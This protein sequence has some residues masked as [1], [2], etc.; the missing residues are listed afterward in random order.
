METDFLDTLCRIC[1][2]PLTDVAC[3][4][5]F[6]SEN[7]EFQIRGCLPILVYQGDGLPQSICENCVK[8][9]KA[10]THFRKTSLKNDK[11]LK[12]LKHKIGP[13]SG[14]TQDAHTIYLGLVENRAITEN[15]PAEVDDFEE[16]S[17]DE[18]KNFQLDEDT[19]N[20]S[21]LT[22][23]T[24][25]AD[26]VNAVAI[27]RKELE[28]TNRI[29]CDICGKSYQIKKKLENHVLTHMI[30]KIFRCEKCR[31]CFATKACLKT[32]EKR[33]DESWRHVCNEC[34]KGFVDKTSFN[35]H[36]RSKHTKLKPFK[37][38]KCSKSFFKNQDLK[39]HVRRN[40]SA[41]PENFAKVCPVCNKT[42]RDSE[43]L[44]LHAK[45]HISLEQRRKYKCN[46]CPSSFACS[47]ALKKHKLVH[48]GEMPF[49]CT[50]CGHKTRTKKGMDVHLIIHS[51]VKNFM[52]EVCGKSFAFENTLKFHARTHTGE[53]PFLCNLCG[54][55]YAQ[56]SSYKKHVKSCGKKKKDQ[57]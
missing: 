13:D 18:S 43:A 21:V 44:R 34:H 57:P 12:E 17:C 54:K 33:H 45:T 48:T 40:H 53:K 50:I 35:Y 26:R 46:T 36:V 16:A 37:C 38:D 5:I 2:C 39:I 32:H 51:G 42:Y 24:L 49:E 7:V 52:C 29:I 47:S 11:L 25:L 4:N 31:K 28:G 15:D 27:S 22:N 56:S 30:I 20:D 3:F 6:D 41:R 8:S 19:C 23:T 1:C 9:L 55:G 10:F 14:A